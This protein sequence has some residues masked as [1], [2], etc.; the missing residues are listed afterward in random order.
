MKKIFTCILFL[1]YSLLL[2][3]QPSKYSI[4]LFGLS[5]HHSY[6]SHGSP[7][8]YPQLSYGGGFQANFSYKWFQISVG[9]INQSQ[10]LKELKYNINDEIDRERRFFFSHLYVPINVKFKI[11]DTK[12]VLCYIPFGFSFG[13]IL[14]KECT[15]IYQNTQTEGFGPLGYFDSQMPIYTNTGI[16]S[17]FKLSKRIFLEIGFDI[18]FRLRREFKDNP[19]HFRLREDYINY[20]LKTGLCVYLGDIK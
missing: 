11:I 16:S 20:A 2:F 9:A 4:S 6:K 14:Q 5:A 15:T 8:V 3:S 18:N 13:R 19:D 17:L 10:K 1:S 7:F 12:N